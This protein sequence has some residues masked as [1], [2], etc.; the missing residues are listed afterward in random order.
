MPTIA[1]LHGA[2]MTNLLWAQPETRVLE[3]FTP[4][5]LNACYEQMA[6][7]GGLL[8][9]GIILKDSGSGDR[10]NEWLCDHAPY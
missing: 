4:G 6:F 8:H 10:L 2:A 3:L 7:Q 5:Y 1:G 9:T